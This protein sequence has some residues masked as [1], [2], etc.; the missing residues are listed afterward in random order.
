MA[1]SVRACQPIVLA[2]DLRVQDQ[3]CTILYREIIDVLLCNLMPMPSGLLMRSKNLNR[4]LDGQIWPLPCIHVQ[5]IV[6]VCVNVAV[7][8]LRGNPHGNK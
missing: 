6:C 2:K 1:K 4:W 3:A 8:G 5:V 7:Q